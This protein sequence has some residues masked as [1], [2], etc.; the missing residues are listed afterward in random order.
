MHRERFFLSHLYNNWR[1]PLGNRFGLLYTA[2]LTIV[3]NDKK[4]LWGDH[5][6]V[7]EK[8]LEFDR[9][10]SPRQKTHVILIQLRWRNTHSHT[11]RTPPL[12]DMLWEMTILFMHHWPTGCAAPASSPLHQQG[13][14]TR[15]PVLKR[16]HRKRGTGESHAGGGGPGEASSWLH[17]RPHLHSV[18]IAPPF[19]WCTPLVSNSRPSE[20]HLSLNNMALMVCLM[21]WNV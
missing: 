7:A 14:P 12:E 11:Q 8:P 16:C 20:S 17:S 10:N 6:R 13:H 9:S 18:P 5:S 21:V 2:R 19:R 4:R 1:N 15:A 3:H